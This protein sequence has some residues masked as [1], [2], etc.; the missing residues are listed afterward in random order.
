MSETGNAGCRCG[1]IRL[2]ISGTPMKVLQCHCA[3]C[4]KISGGSAV[5]I[6]LMRRGDVDVLRGTPAAYAVTAASGGRVT[7]RFCAGC[8]SAL[9]SELEKYPDM[10]AVKSGVWDVGQDMRAD[11]AIWTDSAPLWHHVPGDIPVFEAAIPTP[12]TSTEGGTEQ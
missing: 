5:L 4:Q 10:I 7:R 3:D 1:A 8:G 11:A 12:A 6:A 2:R 9:F